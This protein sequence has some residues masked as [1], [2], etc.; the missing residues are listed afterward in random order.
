M[1]ITRLETSSL[2][3]AEFAPIVDHPRQRDT[4]EHAEG[5]SK[6]HLAE[7]FITHANVAIV[8]YMRQWYKLDGHVRLLLW[9]KERLE[10]PKTL[11]V[12]K[13]KCTTRQEFNQLY[14][15]YN[16]QRAAEKPQHLAWGRLRELRVPNL[17][18]ALANSATSVI[19]DLFRFQL[20]L[21]VG[22]FCT[23]EARYMMMRDWLPQFKHWNRK[24]L[25]R[26]RYKM[27]SAF[28]TTEFITHRLYG[29][30]VSDPFW[31]TFYANAGNKIGQQHD[32]V[33]MLRFVYALRTDGNSAGVNGTRGP[34][35]IRMLTSLAL[36]YF[37]GYRRGETYTEATYTPN[38]DALYE[39]VQANFGRIAHPEEEAN[40]VLSR[41]AYRGAK[42]YTPKSWKEPYY[43]VKDFW[44][45]APRVVKP[46]PA[47][48]TKKAKHRKK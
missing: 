24:A 6:N 1:T 4:E 47:K 15:S 31:D 8:Q 17:T 37:E 10:A 13:Y 46:T 14:L 9:I 32:A 40:S 27:S 12:T 34:Y 29:A 3:V 16:N 35:N 19:G 33:N 43:Q 48:A 20:G 21:Q 30:K 45:Q 39:L 23:D 25:T 2:S 44:K 18:K 26:K 36:Q 42:L 28:M 22:R 41:Y 11:W 7:Y 38:P 5:A